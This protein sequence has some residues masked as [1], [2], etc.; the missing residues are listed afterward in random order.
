[1]KETSTNLFFIYFSLELCVLRDNLSSG[2]ES[3]ICL[4]STFLSAKEEIDLGNTKVDFFLPVIFG[5]L[6]FRHPLFASV[7]EQRINH[8]HNQLKRRY[9]SSYLQE[10][11]VGAIEVAIYYIYTNSRNLDI[12][13][14]IYQ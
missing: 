14:G 7:T 11:A 8:Q 9:Q 2:K 5:I 4:V 3:L 12:L 6:I 1:M 13:I 10:T